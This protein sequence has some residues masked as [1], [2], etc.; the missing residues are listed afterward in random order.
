[1]N[2]IRIIVTLL[3]FVV[4]ICLADENSR[5]DNGNQRS[6][7]WLFLALWILNIGLMWW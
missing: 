5:N 2:V 3:D 1:M 4:A 6:G 7:V